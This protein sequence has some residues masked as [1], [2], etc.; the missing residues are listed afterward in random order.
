MG[1]ELER[2]EK[3]IMFR[4]E[5]LGMLVNKLAESIREI[6]QSI[7][8]MKKVLIQIDLSKTCK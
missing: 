5:R 1:E 6:S 7:L 2:E 8:R 4:R 3:K